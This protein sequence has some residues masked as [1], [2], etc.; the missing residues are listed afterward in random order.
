MLIKHSVTTNYNIEIKSVIV[1]DQ[2]KNNN[3][4]NTNQIIKVFILK[5]H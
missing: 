3:I 2:L 1:F 4:V 5:S